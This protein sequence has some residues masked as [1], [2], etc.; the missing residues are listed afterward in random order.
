MSTERCIG[1]HGQFDA[2][3][4]PTHEYMQSTPGCWA[5]FGRVLARAYQDRRYAAGHRLCV[6]SY[7]VQ[8][9]GVPSRQSIQSVAVHLV[10]LC[11]FLERGLAPEQA[12][13]A[14]LQAAAHKADYH[15]LTPP[16]SL[17]PLSVA[18]V[19]AASGVEA[20]IEMVK[21]WSA[22]MWSVWAPH[23]ATVRAWA[24]AAHR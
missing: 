1:C 12:N 18:D 5:A 3:A 4:G 23:H 21:R 2:V 7:A 13:D 8:H 15:W 11:F 6:D 22:Q 9:P 17:G 24:D 20:H 19:D 14:M 10:R 16:A